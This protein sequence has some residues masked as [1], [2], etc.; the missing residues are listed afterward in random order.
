MIKTLAILAATASPAAA[1]QCGEYD[2]IAGILAD[3]YSENL[4]YRGMTSATSLFELWTSEAGSW[5]MLAVKPDGQACLATS[6]EYGQEF[7]P[8]AIGDPA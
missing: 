1:I 7:A 3:K 5:T 2:K 8:K 6:G 4:H